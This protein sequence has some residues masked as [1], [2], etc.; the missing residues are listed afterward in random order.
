MKYKTYFSENEETKTLPL[1]LSTEDHRL[2]TNSAKDAQVSKS[3]YL[4]ALIRNDAHKDNDN[5]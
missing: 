2:L 1:R 5:E 4:R 3:Q